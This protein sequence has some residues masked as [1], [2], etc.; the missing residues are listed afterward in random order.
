[1]PKRTLSEIDSEDAV[2]DWLHNVCRGRDSCSLYELKDLVQKFP[3]AIRVQAESTGCLPLHYACEYGCADEIIQ[4][5]IE[6]WPQSV[7]VA[8]GSGSLPL[9]LAC[10]YR[11]SL[12]VVQWLV[13]AAPDT[14]RLQ[15]H[16]GRVPLSRAIDKF[17]PDEVIQFL[18]NCWPESVRCRTHQGWLPLKQACL[19]LLSLHVI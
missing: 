3:N 2:V 19:N 13:H 5:L 10:H 16:Q 17:C 9:H 14:I 1:M 6:S 11:V 7:K 15:D 4:F 8:N 12:T 18:L